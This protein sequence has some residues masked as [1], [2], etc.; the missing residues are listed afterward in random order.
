MGIERI[1][2]HAL[3]DAG[4]RPSPRWLGVPRSG[5]V[6]RPRGLARQPLFQA[7]EPDCWAAMATDYRL[8]EEGCPF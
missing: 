7:H 3:D 8:M 6:A 5:D 1:A 2:T 4:H